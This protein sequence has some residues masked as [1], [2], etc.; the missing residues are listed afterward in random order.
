MMPESQASDPV[1]EFDVV[2]CPDCGATMDPNSPV[3]PNCGAEFGFYCPECD[4][5]ISADA[6]VCLWPAP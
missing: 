6:T 1:K 3:C 5:E 2:H 4:E